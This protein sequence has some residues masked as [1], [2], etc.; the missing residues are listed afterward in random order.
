VAAEDPRAVI[1]DRR[2]QTLHWQDGEGAQRQATLPL[3]LFTR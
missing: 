2:T 3:V 1:D